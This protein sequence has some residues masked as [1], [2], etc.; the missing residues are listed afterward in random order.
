M[1][2]TIPSGLPDASQFAIFGQHIAAMLGAAPVWN[3][4]E[5]LEAIGEYAMQDLGVRIGDQDP[6]L[7]QFWRQVADVLGV[8]YDTSHDDDE[9]F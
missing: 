6:Q 3:G 2:A 7:L 8:F 9:G 1:T 5:D 4:A